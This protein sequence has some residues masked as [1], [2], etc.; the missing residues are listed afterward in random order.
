[1]NVTCS[2]EQASFGRYVLCS[3]SLCHSSTFHPDLQH[4][5]QVLPASTLTLY[6]V[7]STPRACE[8]WPHL[9]LK[10]SPLD[11]SSRCGTAHRTEQHSR[12]TCADGGTLELDFGSSLCRWS[13][14]GTSCCKEPKSCCEASL[15]YVWPS[16][17]T[18]DEELGRSV[19]PCGQA[20]PIRAANGG[21]LTVTVHRDTL[22]PEAP[23]YVANRGLGS[24]CSTSLSSLDVCS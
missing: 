13:A 23:E 14:V 3:P 18:G 7:T 6:L 19:D 16:M 22:A 12:P 4:G 15:A 9:K 5:T 10:E 20:S 1:M 17:C 11:M 24:S 2:P 8:R 21:D